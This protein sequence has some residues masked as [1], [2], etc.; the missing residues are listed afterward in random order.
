MTSRLPIYAD[1][2]L[3][4]YGF[5]EKEWFLPGVRLERF[6]ADLA[7]RGLR[8]AVDFR[9][10]SPATDDELL[11]FHTPAHVE[12]V[13]SR[14]A[15][16]E[17]AVDDGPTYARAHVERAA[18][19]VVGAVMDATRRILRGE[20][21]IAFIPIAGFHHAHPNEARMYCLYND[22]A[23]ALTWLLT[24]LGGNLAYID[25]DIHQGDGVYAAFETEPRVWTADLHEDPSTLFPNTPE[26]PGEGHFPGRRTENGHGAGAGTKFNIPL[27]PYT[28]D[29]AYLALWEEAETFIRAAQPEF[30]VF[31]SGVDGLEGDPLSNQRISVG[32]IREVTRR[33]RALAQE[34]AEGRLL[35]LGGGGYDLDNVSN[36]WAAVVEELLSA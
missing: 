4:A 35:V 5:H 3:G 27:D 8:E 1:P 34:V 22:P 26:T 14:C 10:A 30:I 24:Q 16:N 25:I 2:E 29:E 9:E 12:H 6:L 36:G 32:A 20:F 7:D 17:G 11:L 13:R 18:T 28:T 31:E 33:V 15:S 23:I 19:H 21:E